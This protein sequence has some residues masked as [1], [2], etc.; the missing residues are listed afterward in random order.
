MG[1]AVLRSSRPEGRIARM[2]RRE[3]P[4][5]IEASDEV[6]KYRDMVLH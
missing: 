3:A 5:A 4:K 1:M 2:V 6:Y